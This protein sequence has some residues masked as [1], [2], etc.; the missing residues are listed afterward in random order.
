MTKA[1]VLKEIFRDV[2]NSLSTWDKSEESIYSFYRWFVE[3]AAYQGRLGVKDAD[4]AA[5][6]RD[7]L[8]VAATA[9]YTDGATSKQIDYIIALARKNG[10]FNVFSGGRLTKAEASHII[11]AMR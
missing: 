10:D 5:D 8:Q 6:L 9:S 2:R 3:D 4:P 7:M 11:D 1:E